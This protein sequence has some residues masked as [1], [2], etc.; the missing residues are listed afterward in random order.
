MNHTTKL[1]FN[2][3][4]S[5]IQDLKKNEVLECGSLK[6]I[7]RYHYEVSDWIFPFSTLGKRLWAVNDNL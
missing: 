2:W 4:V 5:E 1:D 6:L 3:D 7:A